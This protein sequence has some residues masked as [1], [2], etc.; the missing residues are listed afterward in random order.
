[1]GTSFSKLTKFPRNRL[2][3]QELIRCRASELDL[4]GVFGEPT[5]QTAADELDPTFFWDIEWSC[6]LVMGLQFKQLTEMLTIRLDAP[7]V[8]HALRHLGFSVRDLWTLEADEPERLS[9][10]ARPLAHDAEL[11]RTDQDGEK[12][13]LATRLTE[14]DAYCWRDDLNQSGSGDKYW[15]ITVGSKGN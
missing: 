6:E 15:V 9:E 10:I 1:M 14:R 8:D 7:D 2:L 5:G 4:L 13:Q 11:W 3:E 12:E